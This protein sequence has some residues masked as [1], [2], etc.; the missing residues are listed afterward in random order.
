M[1]NPLLDRNGAFMKIEKIAVFALLAF[2]SL[3]WEAVHAAGQG[4]PA[5]KAC[6]IT[7]MENVAEELKDL[8]GRLAA[9][10]GHDLFRHHCSSIISVIDAKPR[11]TKT[12]TLLLAEVYR[13]FSDTSVL[14]N[15]GAL[16]SYLERKRPFILAW[17]SATD[18]TASLAWLVPPEDWDPDREYPLY[19][20]L[21][22]LSSIYDNPLEYMSRYLVPARFYEGTFEDGYTLLPWGRGNLW[23]MGISE[24]DIFE[25]IE[26]AE[27]LVSVDPGRKYMTGF[28]MGG[29]GAWSIGQNSPETWAAIG[30]FAGALW[31]D[32]GS[33]LTREAVRN[34][35][36]M[37]VYF[38]CGLSDGLLSSNETAYELL[39]ETGNP[40]TIFETFDGGHEAPLE[41]WQ[42]MYRWIRNFSRDTFVTDGH[43]GPSFVSLAGN[44]PNPFNMQ[45][46]IRIFLRYRSR[47]EL[48]IWNTAG[49][50]I[51]TLLDGEERIGEQ[52][53]CW[54][55]CDDS[56]MP[57]PGGVY[58]CRLRA[59]R[60]DS[61]HK[62]LLLK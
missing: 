19:V 53:V 45:T 20:R 56:G 5:S 26:E 35:E 61:V 52:D 50:K 18:G 49:R 31:Y 57:V 29:F 1:E 55:G 27:S 28:S 16:E 59:Y 13:A 40:N 25:S 11:L 51:R 41:Q 7:P 30:V 37:P 2:L 39:L 24:T 15:A 54:D 23:Y 48:V 3:S 42:G 4:T 6:R 17:T 47:A 38:V 58:L 21:H 8:L 12:D 46:T 9:A 62:M 34:L 32:A 10:S 22:G 33:T 14:W 60:T 44:Y 36:G 43:A